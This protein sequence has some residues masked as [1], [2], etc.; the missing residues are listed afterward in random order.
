MK[1]VFLNK[2]WVIRFLIGLSV[3]L[4][5]L[6]LLQKYPGHLY[7]TKMVMGGQF[8]KQ[9]I[10]SDGSKTAGVEIDAEKYFRP[11]KLPVLNNRD[12]SMNFFNSFWKKELSGIVL[13][14]YLLKTPDDTIINY[15]SI[16]RQA[17]NPQKGKKAGCGTLGYQGA[18]Y[19]VA[20]NFLSS[21]Y[22]K[23][24]N[25]N[26][27]L[28]SFENILHINLIKLKRIAEDEKHPNS[29]K[30]F[31]EIEAIEGSE[32]D[33]A[34]FAYYYGYVYV[35]RQGIQYKISDLQF[36]GENYL[37]APYHGWRY[38]AE[39]VVDI[40]Y[41]DWCSLVKER[42]PTQQ[43]GFVKRIYFKGT[44]GNNYMIEFFQLTNDTDI[45]IAQYKQI[46]SGK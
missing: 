10:E 11:S 6:L 41:G 36:Y 43:D 14:D 31:V 24:L 35:I 13:P 37:C 5:L 16:L 2:K 17:A 29:M 28:K 15:F 19:P 9:P 40:K 26:Q 8:S 39:A 44:D 23:K 42:Y 22:Q 30:Y 3:I 1:F 34:Y 25:Y 4:L 33:I 20:Y 27:Y 45:E 12:F 32:K 21:A 38:M 18:P 7:T 46:Q